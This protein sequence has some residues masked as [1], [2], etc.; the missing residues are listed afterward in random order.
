MRRANGT[1]LGEAKFPKPTRRK[2]RY[3][4]YI[5]LHSPERI[6]LEKIRA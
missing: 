4:E 6:K 5:Y 3:E 2:H 1:T